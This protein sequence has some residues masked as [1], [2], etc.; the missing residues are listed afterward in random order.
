MASAEKECGVFEDELAEVVRFAFLRVIAVG[1]V[2]LVA[3]VDE[4]FVL[5]VRFPVRARLQGFV[6]EV[7]SGEER[8]EYGEPAD[9]RVEH[10]D[11]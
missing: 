7:V 4:A 6:V 9:P 2:G 3:E 1:H 10:A 5:E 11:G 8:L